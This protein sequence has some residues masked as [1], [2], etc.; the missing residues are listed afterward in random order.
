ME[1]DVSNCT[2]KHV[3]YFPHRIDVPLQDVRA[4]RIKLCWYRVG[5]PSALQCLTKTNLIII[6]IVHHGT[7]DGGFNILET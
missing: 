3:E 6:R 2:R 1:T 4:L 7:L 5:E